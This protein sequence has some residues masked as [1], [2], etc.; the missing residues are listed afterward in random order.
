MNLLIFSGFSQILQ[1]AAALASACHAARRGQRVLLVSVGPAHLSGAL[2]GQ[3]LGPRPLELESHLA[4]V[5]VNPLDEIGS[6]WDEIRPSLRSGITARLR[7]LGPE[8]IPSFPGMDAIGGLLVAEKARQMGRF[9]LVILDGPSAEGLIRTVSL[10]DVLRWFTRLIVGL[11]RGPGRSRSSQDAAMIPAALLPPSAFAPLQDLRVELEAQRARID[12]ATGS[13]VRLVV[14]P[15]ELAMPGVASSLTSLGLYGMAVD[16]LIVAGELADVPE[17]LRETYSLEASN[18]RPQLRIGPLAASIT[19]RDTWALRGAHLYDDGD[20]CDPAIK[21][22]PP[23]GDRELKLYIP[24]LDPKTLDIALTNEEVVVQLGP[25]RRHVL[26]PGIVT[27]GRL[28]AK[29]DPV[30]VLRLWVE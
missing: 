30:E 8:E 2:L 7:D 29:V 27:G 24:F 20:V 9:D 28:R 14:T 25:L 10:P 3:N 21:P 5:E 17:S 4:A 6:R 23:A 12:A 11:D 1:S 18:V 13:R 19:D 15:D 26:L 16:E 22:L